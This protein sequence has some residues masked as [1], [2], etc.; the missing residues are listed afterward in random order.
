MYRRGFLIDISAELIS[1]KTKL[2]MRHV[3]RQ[4]LTESL[5]DAA[6]RMPIAE[7]AVLQSSSNLD[8]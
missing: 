6:S 5:F 4:A 8:R 7:A 1:Q 3:I 2:E